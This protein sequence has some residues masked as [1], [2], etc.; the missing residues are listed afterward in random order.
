MPVPSYLSFARRVFFKKGVLPHYLVF[1]VTKNCTAACRHCLLGDRQ[2]SE[3]ELQLDE[4]GRMTDY[5]DP[6]LFLLLTGGDP[7]L[8]ED[9]IEIVRLFYRKPGFRNLGMPS[10]GLMTDR[11]V[12]FA[13]TILESCPGIDFAIDISIDDIG[14]SHDMIRN[15]PGLFD[16]AIATYVE[17]RKLQNR[18]SNFNLNIAVTVSKFNQDH[19]MDLY[20]YLVKDLGVVTINHLLCRGNPRD[21]E[22]L[23]VDIDLYRR[24]SDRVDRDIQ[25]RVLKGYSGY[26]FADLINGMK[27]VRERVIRK[28]VKNRRFVIPCYAAR[29]GV[30]LYP[31]GDIAPCELRD[32][33]LG[34]IRDAG[35]N[36]REIVF[37]DNADRIRE[38]IDKE[39]CYCTYECFLTNAIMFNPVM[40]AS[41]ACE[42]MKIKGSRLFRKE[43]KNAS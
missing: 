36:F 7:F 13:E 3:N 9:L 5:M 24:F 10:N 14:S 35:Y 31:D 17:L 18:F 29:L 30:I 33:V 41:V 19:L 6:L 20:D 16:K 37:S 42:V 11:I 1:F 4:I 34:N 12:T 32:E 22:A 27:V 39:R 26:P 25:A 2:K 21:P 23:D 28:I 8:R 38:Q 40:L 15:V 43:P